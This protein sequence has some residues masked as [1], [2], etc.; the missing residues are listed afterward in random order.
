MTVPSTATLALLTR[1][2]SPIT[3]RRAPRS[4]TCRRAFA[5]DF[6]MKSRRGFERLT[7]LRCGN[8][9]RDGMGIVRDHGAVGGI[10]AIEPLLLLHDPAQ[11]QHAQPDA[12][13][14]IEIPARP[15]DV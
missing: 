9:R 3:D 7:A 11:G 14:V 8:Q 12:Y 6:E 13:G 4:R 15:V 10:H 5:R 1:C 2:R